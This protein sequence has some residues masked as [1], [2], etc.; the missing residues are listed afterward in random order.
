MASDDSSKSRNWGAERLRQTEKIVSL[1]RGKRKGTEGLHDTHSESGLR[2][3]KD[4]NMKDENVFD[5][6]I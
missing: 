1:Y 5:E 4:P 6:R 2:G 3:I